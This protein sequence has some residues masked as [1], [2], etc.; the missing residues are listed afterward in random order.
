MERAARKVQAINVDMMK[1]HRDKTLTPEGK[2]QQLDELI[3]EKNALLKASVLDAERAQK[4]PQAL[5]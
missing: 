1:V 2:R 4:K 3:V 5:I